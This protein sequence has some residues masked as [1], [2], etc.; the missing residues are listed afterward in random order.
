MI[1]LVPYYCRPP[2]EEHSRSGKCL[3][4][5]R[6]ML[7]RYS[8]PNGY[9]FPM[10]TDSPSTTASSWQPFSLCCAPASPGRTCRARWSAPLRGVS[11]TPLPRGRGA[12]SEHYRHWRRS[13]NR[14]GRAGSHRREKLGWVQAVRDL[15]LT[16]LRALY[17][18]QVS[19]SAAAEGV[20]LRCRST[21][22]PWSRKRLM[23]RAVRPNF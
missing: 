4:K 23:P 18:G 13:G 8:Y 15:P 16:T 6:E 11:V 5:P 10:G 7:T 9:A 12:Q 22:Q 2:T 17:A 1:S 14:T 3:R 20:R 19:S 21:C